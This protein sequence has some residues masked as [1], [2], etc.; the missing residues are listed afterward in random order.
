MSVFSIIIPVYNVAPWLREC[1][2]SI[3]AQTF[4]DWECICVDDGSS[5]GSGEILDEY[6][7][8]DSRFRVF[9]QSNAGVSAARNMALDRITGDYFTFVDGDDAIVPD[10]LECFDA[11]FQETHDDA[12]L[13]WPHCD[14]LKIDEYRNVPGGFSLL[15]R[16][17]APLSLLIGRHH[18]NGYAVSRVYRTTLFRV[19]RFKKGI[20]ITEDTRYQ[21]D[22]LCVPARW[23]VIRKRYYA[24]RVDRPSSAWKSKAPRHFIRWIEAFSYTARKMRD[25]MGATDDDVKVFAHRWGLSY[26]QN[27]LHPAFRVWKTFSSTDREELW[28]NVKEG[29]DLC[30]VWPFRWTDL[31]RLTA[32]K[33]GIDRLLFPPLFFLDRVRYAIKWRWKR[34]ED[35]LEGCFQKKMTHRQ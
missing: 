19:V 3:V 9:H 34:I 11:A 33:L 25:G 24:Y 30:G 12:I 10:T 13:C 28:E 35:S 20:S 31:A 6:A 32:W 26:A 1:L 23:T 14:F 4:P 8:V 2:D 16:G 7:A 18:A 5:D 15:D 27:A 22:C 21:T 17:Q 29:R